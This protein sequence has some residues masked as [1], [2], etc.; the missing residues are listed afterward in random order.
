MRS[1]TLIMPRR[2]PWWTSHRSCKDHRLIYG[3]LLIHRLQLVYCF[4]VFFNLIYFV[5]F[6]YLFF[7]RWPFSEL[8]KQKVCQRMFGYD[9]LYFFVVNLLLKA[10][11]VFPKLFSDARILLE[12]RKKLQEYCAC[13]IFGILQCSI[14]SENIDITI[15]FAWISISRYYFLNLNII[16]VHA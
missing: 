13:W 4:L 7:L 1:K 12:Y 15:V 5:R 9:A 6:L 14:F 8:N 11:F 3:G 2:A 16:F 10:C